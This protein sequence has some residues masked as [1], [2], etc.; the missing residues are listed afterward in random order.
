[1][2]HGRHIPEG[3]P[4][5]SEEDLQRDHNLEQQKNDKQRYGKIDSAV[6]SDLLRPLFSTL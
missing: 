1:M 6:Y 5:N 2:H 3:K 4:T